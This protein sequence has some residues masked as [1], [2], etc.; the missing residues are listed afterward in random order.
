MVCNQSPKGA[1]RGAPLFILIDKSYK[2]FSLKKETKNL[3]NIAMFEGPGPLPYF[4]LPDGRWVEKDN[5]AYTRELREYEES[6]HSV[7]HTSVI[8]FIAIAFFILTGITLITCYV[9]FC[10]SDW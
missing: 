3:K 10:E 1:P 7:E 4:Q 5:E 9:I 8:P 2:K 6:L